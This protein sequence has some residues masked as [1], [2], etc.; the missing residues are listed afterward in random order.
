MRMRRV[1]PNASHRRLIAS[2]MFGYASSGS[3]VLRGIERFDIMTLILRR[4]RQRWQLTINL[5]V[6]NELTASVLSAI[7]P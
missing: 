6:L 1:N 5:A 7:L 4:L 3:T 2:P